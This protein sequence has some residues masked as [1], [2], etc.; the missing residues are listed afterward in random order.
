ME[1]SLSDP[2]HLSPDTV[3]QNL[4]TARQPRQG[5]FGG[6]KS[7][8]LRTIGVLV[9][10]LMALFVVT[11]VTHASGP[12]APKVTLETSTTRATAHP[13]AR[14]TID[15]SDSDTNIK[16]LTLSLPDGFWGSLAAVDSKCSQADAEAG[17]CTDAS[18]IG[19]VTATAKIEDGDTVANGVL[20]GNVYLTEAFDNGGPTATNPSKL[21]PAGISIEVDAKVGEVDLGKVIVSGRAAVRH[22][23]VGDSLPTGATGAISGLDT[24]VSDIPE[25]ITDSHGRTV[26]YKL[27]KMTVDL[28]SK[29]EDSA[30]PTYTP[31]LLTNPSRCGTYEISAVATPYGGGVPAASDDDYTVDHCAD[32]QF[33]PSMTMSFT[34]AVVPA[35]D[36]N[37][38]PPVEPVEGIK[39]NVQFPSRAGQP[40][41]S[42]AMDSVSVALPRTFGANTGGLGASG[43]MCPGGSIKTVSGVAY[44]GPGACSATAKAKAKIGDITLTTPLL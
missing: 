6:M 11:G 28:V 30:S 19:T 43:T 29:L 37:Q 8:R 35:T 38:D 9:A 31:P 44:F 39:A 4:Q 7:N 42:S 17:T 40:A 21:D 15:N 18:K 2:C 16:D 25:S 23:T 24:I 20:S 26:N 41:S 14:I 3:F 22:A 27:E 5:V 32:A 12:F 10:G 36:V 33:D 1:V 34:D 13:D